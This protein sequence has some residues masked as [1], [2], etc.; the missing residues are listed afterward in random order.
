MGS[1][2][3]QHKTHHISYST[4]LLVAIMSLRER[5]KKEDVNGYR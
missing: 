5:R 4:L 2:E 3:R 1:D